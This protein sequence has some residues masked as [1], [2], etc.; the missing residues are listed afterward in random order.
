MVLWPSIWIAPICYFSLSVKVNLTLLMKSYSCHLTREEKIKSC[1]V[2]LLM[3]SLLLFVFIRCAWGDSPSTAFFSLTFAKSPERPKKQMHCFVHVQF[4]LNACWDQLKYPALYISGQ[5]HS[6]IFLRCAEHI[7][8]LCCFIV[9]IKVKVL[10]YYPGIFC[11][12]KHFPITFKIAVL[13]TFTSLQTLY[14]F[15]C[16]LVD[17]FL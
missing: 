8:P 3:I 10:I 15:S 12:W 1:C 16:S 2:F 7:T 6:H 13:K 11:F 4:Q 5:T 14:C 17:A 9:W